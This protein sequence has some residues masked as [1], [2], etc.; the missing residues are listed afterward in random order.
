MADSNTGQKLKVFISYSRRDSADFAD[1]LV[2]GLEL[3]GFAPFLD[4]HDIAVGEDWELQL[5]RLIQEA[6]AVVFVVSP[7]AMKS[8]R[9]G[10]EI[11]RALALS[12]RLLPVIFK[13]LP[14]TD[15]PQSLRRLQ[16]VRFDVG[17]GLARP[18]AQLAEALRRDADWIREHT[19]LGELAARWQVRDRSESLLLRGDD[20]DAAKVWAIKRKNEVPEITDLQRAFLNASEQ[21]EAVRIV[22][23]KATRRQVRRMEAV[24][25]V[26]VIGIAAWL[27]W[28]NWDYLKARTVTLVELLWPKGLT[29]AAEHALKPRDHFKE[30]AN[31][32]EMI[33]IPSGEFM[34]GSDDNNDEKPVHKVIIAKS[35]AVSRFEVTFD[36]Y[37]ACVI[38]G[39][40][41]YQPSDQGWGRGTRPVVNVNLG[42]AQQYVSWLSKRTGKPYRLL[43]EA[44]WEY[45]ARAGTTSRYSFEAD[46]AALGEYAWYSGNSEGQI[47]PVGEK[48]PNAFGL[49][50]MLGNVWE[51]VQDC[52]QDSYTGAPTD[53]SA[54][55]RTDCGR[56]VVRGGSWGADPQHFRSAARRSQASD[57][58]DSIFGFRVG[59]TLAP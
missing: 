33:T 31:C 46:G 29:R 16:F 17:P 34:M 50:D 58:R 8:E 20:L 23:A 26:S 6:D 43:S 25:G 18:L 59:R 35:F 49:Y 9:C 11:D 36:E 57:V 10:W 2:V 19:R 32:P 3:A 47:R 30:C 56:R 28:S 13:P 53:G 45:A 37:D 22:R 38:L 14:E 51:W 12:R 7:E 39:G 42:D 5:G 15:I 55:T 21:A 27:A 4:R 41:A 52:Y 44:E 24:I 48:K 54:R 1:E 40:C